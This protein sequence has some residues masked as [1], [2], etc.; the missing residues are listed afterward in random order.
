MHVELFEISP[1]PKGRLATMAR[2]RGGEWLP[3]EIASL[4]KQGVTGVV[5]LLTPPEIV[6]FDLEA[7]PELCARF[8]LSFW[9]H[10]I[11]D[12]GLPSESGFRAFMESLVSV[13]HEDSFLAIHCFAG[14]GRSSMTAAAILVHLGM[15]AEEAF[16]LISMAR[17]YSVPDTEEQRDFIV[18]LE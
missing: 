2:P 3:D 7:E 8:G 6:A 14:I 5:S 18:N 4:K 12:H 9:N 10:P 11:T 1:C 16:R 17:G 13:F 15:P